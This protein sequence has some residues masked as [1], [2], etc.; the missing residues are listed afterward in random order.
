M[1][2]N[3]ALTKARINRKEALRRKV[4]LFTYIYAAI[5]ISMALFFIIFQ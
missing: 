3:H 1:K 5:A 2:Y 4:E